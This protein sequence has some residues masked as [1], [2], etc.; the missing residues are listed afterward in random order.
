MQKIRLDLRKAA[1]GVAC[2]AAITMFAS[3]EKSTSDEVDTPQVNNITFTRCDKGID[4][5]MDNASPYV[6]VKFTSTG[7]HITH[8]NFVVNCAFD[9]VLV[10][11]TF[12]NGVLTITAQGEPNTANCV[13][14]TDV[15]YTISGISEN[16]IDKIVINGKVVWN[17]NPQPE[18]SNFYNLEYRIGLWINESR[19]DTLEFINSTELIRKG[20]A[21]TYEEYLYRIEEN[22]LIIS[23]LN[24]EIS[25]YHPILKVEKDTV[26]LNNM[27]ITIGL[28]DNSGT[29]IKQ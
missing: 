25:T 29:F 3:C 17:A 26:V 1:A 5:T 7:V 13:C 6:D 16:E 21:Y 18:N 22:T 4:D 20:K 8:S 28:Y 27:Y 2:L 15:S 19:K 10:T 11:Q 14:Q 24:S 9:T 23:T 12:E